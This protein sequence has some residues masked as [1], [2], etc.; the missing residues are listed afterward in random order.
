MKKVLLPMVAVCAF[1]APAFAED[2]LAYGTTPETAK[3]FPAYT[4]N[5]VTGMYNFGGWMVTSVA[6]VPEEVYFTIKY[7]GETPAMWG[8]APGSNDHM[9]WVYLC[10]E[11]QEALQM[12]EGTNSYILFPG[13]EYL[14]KIT[15]KETGT[16]GAN[17]PLALPA[18][19]EGQRKYFP[20]DITANQGGTFYQSAGT[21]K[22]YLYSAP[23]ANRLNVSAKALNNSGQVIGANTDITNV[24]VTHIECPGGTNVSTGIPGVLLIGPYIKAGRNIVS[25]T[26]AE[27]APEGFGIGFSLD[28]LN[29]QNC[30][31]KLSYASD[32]FKLDTPLEYP[33]AYYT[34][35][36]KFEVPEDGTYTFINHGAAGTILNVGF[37]EYLPTDPDDPYAGKPFKCLTEGMKTATVGND[38]AVVV[39][40]NLKKGQTMYVQSDAFGVIGSG[41][42]PYLKI[43]KGTSAI[44]EIAADGNTLKVNA[45]DGILSVESVLLASGAEV[46]VYDMTAR[47]V[48]SS[49]AAAGAD[50][51]DMNLNVAQGVYVVVVYGKGNSESAKIVIK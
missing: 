2:E 35:D 40:E 41:D 28:A 36:Y 25:V 1:A 46:A 16:Y 48:A 31:N 21:T 13:Q 32:Q 4:K 6:D 18:T 51:L 34:V 39:F 22:Y 7:E 14:V 42:K 15:P 30:G 10:N 38:D 33:D 26:V 45:A 9:V 24:E 44:N 43:T 23:Y 47:K 17:G 12:M 19:M 37:M 20:Q 50:R 11:G 49:V 5:P 3:P 8:D 27:T 29:I